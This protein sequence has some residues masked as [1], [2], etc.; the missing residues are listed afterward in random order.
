M[1]HPQPGLYLLLHP[2]AVGKEHLRAARQW[3][4]RTRTCTPH[5]PEPTPFPNRYHTPTQHRPRRHPCPPHAG[6]RPGPGTAPGRHPRPHQRASRPRVRAGGAA[7]PTPTRRRPAPAGP[8]PPP[9]SSGRFA[10]VS[11]HPLPARL[12]PPHRG[13]AAPSSPR[14]GPAEPPRRPGR[15]CLGPGS[16]S[17]AGPPAPGITAGPKSSPRPSGAAFTPR[18]N[19][20][21]QKRGGTPSGCSV[22]GLLVGQGAHRPAP[23]AVWAVRGGAALSLELV[24]QIKG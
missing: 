24:S 1:V 23:A 22:A 14:P 9:G 15:R 12:L 6:T 7:R 5:A 11:A 20:F 17:P 8:P 19:A 18:C 13:T 21:G 16:P 4:T 3:H 2:K 10:P